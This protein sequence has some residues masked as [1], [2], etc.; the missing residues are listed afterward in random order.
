MHH[1]RGFD[2]RD[3]RAVLKVI[4]KLERSECGHTGPGPAF[5]V[6]DCT[7]DYDDLEAK[8]RSGIEAEEWRL[9][10]Q[11]RFAGQEQSSA[12]E[13]CRQAEER[14][15][16]FVTS[17]LRAET[18]P[19]GDGATHTGLGWNNP[20]ASG[21]A[22]L[23]FN[24][25][26]VK[27]GGKLAKDA[28]VEVHELMR[29]LYR[30]YY[31][32]VRERLD[33]QIF[34]PPA[35]T[36]AVVHEQSRDA[37]RGQSGRARAERRDLSVASAAAAA[38]QPLGR[39]ASGGG[40]AIAQAARAK[41][42]QPP[43]ASQALPASNEPPAVLIEVELHHPKKP[44]QALQPTSITRLM[45]DLQLPFE[46]EL[47]KVVSQKL[48]KRNSPLRKMFYFVY[49][50]R[51]KQPS[52]PGGEVFRIKWAAEAMVSYCP[53]RAGENTLDGINE[54]SGE[55]FGGHGAGPTYWH[56]K[57]VPGTK[58]GPIDFL[59][60]EHIIEAVLQRGS[61]AA[62]RGTRYQSTVNAGGTTS[63]DASAA[64]ADS[65]RI[66]KERLQRCLQRV[67]ISWFFNART[68]ISSDKWVLKSFEDKGARLGTQYRACTA[69]MRPRHTRGAVPCTRP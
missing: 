56:A 33:P 9:P 26:P 54:R 46:A 66:T 60:D 32:Y 23:V 17:R 50:E 2:H 19:A 51:V 1:C 11:K 14:F 65:R 27:V 29:H 18:Q 58:V 22:V 68:C 69:L 44:A 48:D 38:A 45:P 59:K 61:I 42:M 4:C 25:R 34:R 15:S 30:V 6:Y 35:E 28:I 31:W 41:G 40:G 12:T 8:L 47:D 7:M 3:A 64:A 43:N 13:A 53:Y 52:A 67:V 16:S 5:D 55:S 24:M 21:T 63:H 62:G 20:S 36:A 39:R 57:L 37:Q 10:E 49:R